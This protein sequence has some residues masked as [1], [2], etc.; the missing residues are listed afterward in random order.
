[1]KKRKKANFL[2]EKFPY[3]P[4]E[5]RKKGELAITTIILI[6]LGMLVLIGVIFLLTTQKAHFS[7]FVNMFRSKSNVDNVVSSCNALVSSESF[8]SYCCEKKNVRVSGDE[9][10]LTCEE[11]KEKDFISGRIKSLDC[12]GQIC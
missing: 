2:K 7:D 1:M 5:N 10:E 8:Y 11:L 9:F 4:F 12:S 3:F 6:V